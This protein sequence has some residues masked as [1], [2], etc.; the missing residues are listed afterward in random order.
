MT[1]R[2][3]GPEVCPACGVYHTHGVPE[4]CEVATR[5]QEVRSQPAERRPA[6]MRP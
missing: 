3:G 1:I 4:E 5:R 6:K 2:P